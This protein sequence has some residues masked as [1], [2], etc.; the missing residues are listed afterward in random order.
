MFK[1]APSMSY[2]VYP[3]WPRLFFQGD[4]IKKEKTNKELEQQIK[5]IE[6]GC[7]HVNLKHKEDIAVLEEDV[8]KI[9]ANIHVSP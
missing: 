1:V 4:I 2:S 7:D 3:F 6:K 5:N 8:Q 9:N